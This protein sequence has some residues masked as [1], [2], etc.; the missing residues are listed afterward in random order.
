MVSPP[1]P[2]KGPASHGTTKAFEILDMLWALRLA[3]GES[4][5][6]IGANQGVERRILLLPRR[7]FPHEA[8]LS[9]AGTSLRT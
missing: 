8:K 2:V 1:A 6:L 4:I 3:D 9:T 5:Q 7:R